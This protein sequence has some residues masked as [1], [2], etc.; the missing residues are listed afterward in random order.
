M[1]ILCP[2]YKAEEQRYQCSEKILEACAP[3][4]VP[5]L[6]FPAAVNVMLRRRYI[7]FKYE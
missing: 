4:T 5:V 7:F 6:V 1:D 3:I 2:I